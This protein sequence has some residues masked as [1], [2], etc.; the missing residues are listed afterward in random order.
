MST[1][2]LGDPILAI[3]CKLHQANSLQ[4]GFVSEHLFSVCKN[5]L[6][7]LANLESFFYAQCC[8]SAEDALEN[9]PSVNRGT[10]SKIEDARGYIKGGMGQGHTP[11]IP[12]LRRR[13]WED[14]CNGNL[15]INVTSKLI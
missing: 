8:S 13:R 3:G 12:V 1:P 2:S 7:H 11:L 10:N 15:N 6:S 4:V 14:L 9:S 5:S